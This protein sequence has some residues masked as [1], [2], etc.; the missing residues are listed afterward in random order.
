MNEETIIER[1]PSSNARTENKKESGVWKKV[2]LGGFSGV[3]MGAGAM[4]AGQSLAQ[5]TPDA[6]NNAEDSSDVENPA[7]N[8]IPV[9]N[10]SD[11]LSFAEAFDQAR[12]EVGPGGVFY[13]HG[14]IYNTFSEDEWN[15]MSDEERSEFAQQVHPEVLPDDMPTPT[16]A[17]PDLV[18]HIPV[19][20]QDDDVEIA[21]VHP[22]SNE[23]AG[24]DVQ[25][26]GYGMVDGHVAMGID[27]TGN[28]EADVALVDVNN[29]NEIDNQDI[30]TDRGGN[31]VTVGELQGDP[32]YDTPVTDPNFSNAM[33]NP[34][35]APDQPD[36]MN[37]GLV[38]A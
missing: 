5:E 21:N 6:D 36:Y 11:G 19:G 22:A 29:N 37:D 35:V 18:A 26:V 27:L 31:S 28:G 16:D 15:A 9:A 3:L 30:I 14:G 4:Y 20:S 17:Q 34:E 25:V 13:W 10:I 12:A 8:D 2:T 38:E 7:E 1:R 24:D 32:S 33:E 23:D